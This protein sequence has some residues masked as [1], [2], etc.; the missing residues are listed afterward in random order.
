MS[1]SYVVVALSLRVAFF[2]LICLGAGGALSVLT[3]WFWKTAMPEP[4]ALARLEIMSDR[5]Y[6]AASARE[7]ELLLGEADEVMPVS[8]RNIKPRVHAP[9][10]RPRVAPVPERR[11]EVPVE[12]RVDALVSR[13]PIDPL[14]K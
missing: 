12:V 6:E 13:K 5:R 7:R 8:V 4:P 9:A 2:S 3:W 14:L 1:V 10:P 11:R